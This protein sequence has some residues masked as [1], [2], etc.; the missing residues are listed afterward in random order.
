MLA[1]SDAAHPSGQ[2]PDPPCAGSVPPKHLTDIGAV[3]AHGHPVKG[4]LTGSISRVRNA[5]RR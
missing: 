3:Q 2:T 4:D 1:F 5:Q